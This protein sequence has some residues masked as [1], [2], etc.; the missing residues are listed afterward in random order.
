MI[1]NSMLRSTR[2]IKQFEIIG[3]DHSSSADFNETQDMRL[4]KIFKKFGNDIQR[5]ELQNI[6]VPKN[7]Y[8]LLSFLPN[9]HNIKLFSVQNSE[10][11]YDEKINRKIILSKL[12]ELTIRNSSEFVNCF[13]K[14]LQPDILR[15]IQFCDVPEI[16]ADRSNIVF[17]F[18]HNNEEMNILKRFGTFLNLTKMKITRY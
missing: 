13:L 18:M 8:E 4:G 9:L 1:F 5:L 14:T 16:Y 17:E 6:A 12:K 7:A 2:R 11:I 15:K 3:L 10:S